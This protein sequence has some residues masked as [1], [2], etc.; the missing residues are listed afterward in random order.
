MVLAPMTASNGIGI[1]YL[2]SANIGHRVL[3]CKA[4]SEL[5]DAERLFVLCS[6][7]RLE[8]S[9]KLAPDE[10]SEDISLLL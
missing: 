2:H 10:N 9:Q 5:G 6:V 3:R 7:I 4:T 8:M 1:L